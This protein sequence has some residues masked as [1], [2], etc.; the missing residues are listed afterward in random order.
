MV[1]YNAWSAIHFFIDSFDL[2]SILVSEGV[3]MTHPL[4]YIVALLIV[5][6]VVCLV[7]RL[8]R[9]VRP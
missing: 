9:G 8:L 1:G 5:V 6:P 4:E 7:F 3:R 2:N